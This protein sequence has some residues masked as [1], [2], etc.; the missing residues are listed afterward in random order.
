MN[1]QVMENNIKPML[2]IC[3]AAESN[4]GGI[5]GSLGFI[6]ITRH[7]KDVNQDNI[8]YFSCIQLEMIIFYEQFWPNCSHYGRAPIIHGP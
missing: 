8:Y 2:G 3:Q 5:I 6:P 7:N 4:K 1:F